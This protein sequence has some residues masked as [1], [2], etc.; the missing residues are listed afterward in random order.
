MSPIQEDTLFNQPNTCLKITPNRDLVVSDAPIPT[1]SP[2]QVLVH[3]KCT[4]VCGSDIHLWKEG[5]IGSLEITEDLIIGHETSGQIIG[6][7]SKVNKD[8]KIG[9]RVAIEPQT[10][11]GTCFLCTNGNLN[12]CMNVDFLGMP[13][14]EGRC[15]SIHGS[16]QRFL[17]VD[18]MWVHK[19]P[20]NMTYEEG[21]LVEVFSV[22]YH[23]IEKAGGLELGKPCMI[24][25]CGPIGLATLT[26]ANAAGAY[27][28]VV[29]DVSQ[30]RLDFAKTLV[31]SIK[32][33]KIDT[34]K[35]VVDNATNIRNIFGKTE[36]EMPSYV[37]ECTGV[38]S[39]IN[40]MCYVVRRKGCL[41]I[42]GVSGKNEIDQFPF[43]TISFGEV[44]LKFVNRYHDSWPPVI[45]LISSGKVDVKKFVT[46]TFALEHANKALETVANPKI[47]SIKVMVKDDVEL[48]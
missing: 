34:T 10:P 7:G 21:A 2:N 45:N 30:D 29:S 36:Y 27:P 33:Y 18:P 46:H 1:C 12:L 20:E 16:M 48:L 43:M 38:H 32:T 22:G 6:I 8:L 39:S 15:P 42:L 41:T 19:I 4:G 13:G 25:G 14:M 47:N 24:A 40:T 35:G 28:I 26:L 17:T 23:G 44:D 3:I 9:D 11:C 37:L 31:P 5:Q